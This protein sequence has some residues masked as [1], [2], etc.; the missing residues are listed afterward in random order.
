MKKIFI[1]CP[2]TKYLDGNRFINDNLKVFVENMYSICQTYASEVFLALKREEYGKKL[3]TDICTE[4]DY[5]EMQSSD[6]VVAIPEDSKGTA[7]ELGWAS[8][9]KKKL[10]LIL[11]RNT[12]YTP[13]V[14]G[15]GDITDAVCIW[16][17][18]ELN[19]SVLAQIP[20][21]IER[22]KKGLVI[23]DE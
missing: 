5:E 10:I 13:L 21:A 1:A 23:S 20:G 22:L 11:D 18:G 6:L 16:Y 2:I 12:R 14:Y 19:E 15:L 9:M 7:V 8:V 4:L 3:M 17:E